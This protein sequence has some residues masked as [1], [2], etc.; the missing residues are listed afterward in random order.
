MICCKMPCMYP[1]VSIKKTRGRLNK[2]LTRVMAMCLGFFIILVEARAHLYVLVDTHVHAHTHTAGNN[3]I[4]VPLH[5]TAPWA[6][7]LCP[8]LC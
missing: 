1:P 7:A 8:A 3:L 4:S 5:D 2:L 6:S